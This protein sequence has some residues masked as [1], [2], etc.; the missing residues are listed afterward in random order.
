[1]AINPYFKL[2]GLSVTFY[3]S[4]MELPSIRN[5]LVGV[6]TERKPR[7]RVEAL[8]E[9]NLSA[10]SGDVIGL[11]GS[12]G[13]GKTTLMR[14]LAGIYQPTSGSIKTHGAIRCIFDM[15]AGFD[16]DLTGLENIYRLQFWNGLSRWDTNRR[17]DSIIDFSE[18]G[19]AIFRPLRTYSNGMKLRLLFSCLTDAPSD[20][21]LID[22]LISVG[23]K[24]FYSKSIERI[25]SISQASGIVVIASHNE[26]LLKKMQTRSL[27]L[28]NG[29]IQ[30]DV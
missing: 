16:Q 3:I 27:T 1:M 5:E 20:I 24:N 25:R 6:F 15:G 21:L 19:D 14:T 11:H 10:S 18:L 8:K 29:V 7:Q 30:S 17:I 9:I 2:T 26:E 23:D 12:N 4:D 22:E 13:S 28:A